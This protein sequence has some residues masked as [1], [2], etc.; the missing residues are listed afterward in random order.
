MYH[1]ADPQLHFDHL[2]CK[3]QT[4]KIQSSWI[5]KILILNIKSIMDNKSE[6]D[7]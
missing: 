7:T 1:V 5:L 6:E 2:H 3:Q 4:S